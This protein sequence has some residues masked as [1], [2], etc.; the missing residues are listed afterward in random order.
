MLKINSLQSISLDIIR[1]FAAQLVLVGHLLSFCSLA[2]LPYIQNSGV[3]LFFILSGL[4]ISYTIFY[5]SQTNYSFQEFFIERFA[6][7][8]SGLVPSLLF[9][10]LIDFIIQNINPNYYQYTNAYNIKT[11]LG[12]LLMLQD[13]HYI[14]HFFVNIIPKSLHITS[15]GSGRPLWTLAIE[16]WLY[17]FLGM[18]Y[19]F[20]V[21]SS[22]RKYVLLML[23]VSVVPLWNLV[24]GRGNGLSVVWILGIIVTM[25]VFKKQFFPKTLSLY[26]SVTTLVFALFVLIYHEKAY[27]IH[28][29]FLIACSINFMLLFQQGNIK[30]YQGAKSKLIKFVANYSFTLYLIHYSLIELILSLELDINKYLLAFSCFILAN[31]TAAFIA[32]FTEMKHKK[33]AV[34]LK[35]LIGKKNVK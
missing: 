13:Y 24:Y 32:Y 34:K 16:W 30:L 11:F 31:I 25:F 29:A 3:V 14:G 6:R 18:I 15:F 9:I 21:R 27:N 22:S 33:L 20:Y 7:I 28:F 19:F 35:I 2:K 26:F 12:N 10:L 23:L 4:I 5:K 1:L 8:Y 17:M